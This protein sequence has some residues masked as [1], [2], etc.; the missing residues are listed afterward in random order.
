MHGNVQCGL[1]CP[2]AWL[3]HM[4]RDCGQA[5]LTSFFTILKNFEPLGITAQENE[6]P[7]PR[8]GLLSRLATLEAKIQRLVGLPFQVQCSTCAVHWI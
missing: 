8:D 6:G 4:A 7:T 2:S 5:A 1:C 3:W